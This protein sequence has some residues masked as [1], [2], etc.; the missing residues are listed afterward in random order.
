[1]SDVAEFLVRAVLIGIGATVV[2]DLWSL[3]ATRAF[4]TSA[5]NWTLVGRWIGH[6]PQGQFVQPHISKARSVRGETA[7]GWTAH[8]AIGIFYAAVLI[9]IFGLDW[10]RHPTP[11]P[12]F[13]VGLAAMT[14]PLF[15][16]QPGMGL[17]IA[18]SR[19]QNPTRRRLNTLASHTAFSAGLY[20]CAL[21]TA[22]FF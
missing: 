21:L 16:M 7:L 1:M 14:A 4:N 2:L 13:V 19:T 9:A 17:G 11:L 6:F 10:A 18:A 12:A 15:V 5:P 3:F 22:K 20:V 8:F